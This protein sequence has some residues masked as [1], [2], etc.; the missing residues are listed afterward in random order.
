MHSRT[1]ATLRHALFS[2]LLGGIAAVPSA[3]QPK[4]KDKDTASTSAIKLPSGAIIV[5]TSDPDLI[6]KSASIYLT[7]ERYKELT[8]QIEL[9]KKQ[10]NA[11][12]PSVPSACELEGRIEQRGMQ[13]VVRLRATFRFRTTQPRSVVFLGCQKMQLVEAKRD[14]G[15]LPLLAP[16]EKGLSVLIEE[17]G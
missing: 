3:A 5:V 6:D 8:D 9:L 15:K 1:L 12:K 7:P 14:D 11:E 13:S 10:I 17:A 16:G 4:P 2:L